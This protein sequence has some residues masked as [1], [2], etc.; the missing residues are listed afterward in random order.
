MKVY[1]CVFSRLSK[2]SIPDGIKSY[3]ELCT[4]SYGKVKLVLKHNRYF[5]ESHHPE[6][7]QKLLKDP[8]IQE[9][10]LRPP[11]TAETTSV[12][13][14]GENK[15][16]KPNKNYVFKTQLNFYSILL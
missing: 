2:S 14:L 8:V 12:T 6:I 1:L 4:L 5:V 9:C 10:R 3:I 15:F 13:S 7:L 11:V 16:R